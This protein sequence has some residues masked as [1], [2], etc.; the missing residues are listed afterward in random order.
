M[1]STKSKI[2]IA[3]VISRT[4]CSLRTIAGSPPTVEGVRRNGL[5]WSLDLREGIDLAIY[6]GVYEKETTKAIRR[7]V[8]PGDVV[9]DIGANSGAH[10]LELARQVGPAGKVIAFEPTAYAISR[11]GRQLAVNEGV[12]APVTVEQVMLT[13]AGRTAAAGAI[14]SRWPLHEAADLNEEHRGKLESTDGA[15]AVTLDN[16][17]GATGIRRVDFIKLDVDGF[18]CEVLGGARDCLATMKPVI[19]LELA[20]YALRQQGRSLG[21][22]V[23]QIE[24]AGYRLYALS[25]AALPERPDVLERQI[26]DGSGWNAVA[27]AGPASR[28]S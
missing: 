11:L 5:L 28:H 18:E 20:P 27:R 3:G 6:L 13:D 9:L 10:T 23:S 15:R 21:E 19:L 25:G 17:L 14:Y 24:A 12:A 4:L 26:R 7:I 8:K 1:L 16:Y 22:L 2:R